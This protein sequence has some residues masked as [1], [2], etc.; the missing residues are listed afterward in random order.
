LKLPGRRW[1]RGEV[2]GEVE[3]EMEGGVK[4]YEVYDSEV[5]T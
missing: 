2:E 5:I 3:D 4:V 1:L